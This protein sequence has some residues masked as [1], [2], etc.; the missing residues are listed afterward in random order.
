[1]FFSLACLAFSR[2]VAKRR[3]LWR[4]CVEKLE[5][6]LVHLCRHCAKLAFIIVQ[7]LTDVLVC[8][9][10]DNNGGII[11]ALA[12]HSSGWSD[13]SLG[14]NWS[15]RTAP[16]IPADKDRCAGPQCPP[17]QV[18]TYSHSLSPCTPNSVSAPQ[19]PLLTSG[20]SSR[21]HTAAG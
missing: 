3:S 11:D 7:L 10:S 14:F 15:T 16:A 6:V 20:C 13:R 21:Y 5:A 12:L 8:T 17:A 18:H 19:S 1:M 2:A 4:C 9:S